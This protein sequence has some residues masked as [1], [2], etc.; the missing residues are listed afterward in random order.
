MRNRS[1]NKRNTLGERLF[2]PIALAAS[3]IAGAGCSPQDTE[4]L[5]RQI[6]DQICITRDFATDMY[7]GPSRIVIDGTQEILDQGNN[8]TDTES[9]EER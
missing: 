2:V 3:Y 1:E 7:T 4:Y 8:N 6:T 9:R 5:S